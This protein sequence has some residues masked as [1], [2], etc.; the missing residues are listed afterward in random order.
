MKIA[1]LA[2]TVLGALAFGGTVGLTFR[3]GV[4]G[5]PEAI[6]LTVLS[7]ILLGGVFLERRRVKAAQAASQEGNNHLHTNDAA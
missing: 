3:R 7:Y 6:G 2:L 5:I 1:F 4:L